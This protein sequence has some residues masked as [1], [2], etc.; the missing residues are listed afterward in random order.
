MPV[1]SFEFDRFELDLGGYE[2]RRSGRKVRLQRVPMDLLILLVERHGALITREEIATRLWVDAQVDTQS[3]INTAI[4]KIRQALGDGGEEPKFI[5]TVVG[6]G[7]RFIAEVSTRT[8]VIDTALPVEARVPAMPT[9]MPVSSPKRPSLFAGR[10]AL[11]APL[12]TGVVVAILYGFTLPK[13][14]PFTIV[15]FTALPGP[16]SWPAFSPDGTRVAF[17]WTSATDSCSHIYVKDVRPRGTRSRRTGRRSVSG[18]SR[19]STRR[20]LHRLPSQ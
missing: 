17:G 6:K 2:L 11:A 7:Y 15:P 9:E 5:E 10:A 20:T 13:P 12:A 3:G 19:P 14:G 1:S 18:A 8:P 4:R 16:Q